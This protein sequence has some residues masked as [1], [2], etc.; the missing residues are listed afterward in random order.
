[1]GGKAIADYNPD[2]DYK[3]E[4]SDPEIETVNEDKENSDAEY[5]NME[6]S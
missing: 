6:I 4:G 5:V 1:M 2:V 3:P